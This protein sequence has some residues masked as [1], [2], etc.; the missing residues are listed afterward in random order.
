M[1]GAAK[2]ANL[3]LR[4]ATIADARAIAHLVNDAFRLERLVFTTEDRTNPEEV[5]NMLQKGEFLL[6][7]DGWAL[8]GC[9]YLE[10]QGERCYLGLLSID[11]ARQRAGLG[12]WL[13]AAAEERCRNT[14][15]RR[16]DLRF[17][18]LRK[19]LPEYYRRLGYIKN[20]TAPF[21]SHVKTTQPCHFI[22][23]SKKLC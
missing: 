6:A 8:V 17:V 11:P 5:R 18:N 7:E 16:I 14:G 2:I 3:R 22:N 15:I 20:G 12:T 4:S 10:P 19:G 1:N 9:V 21:P 13:M 23:M